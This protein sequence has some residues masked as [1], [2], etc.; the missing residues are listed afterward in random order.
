MFNNN[1]N[2]YFFYYISHDTASTRRYHNQLKLN[3]QFHDEKQYI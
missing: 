3:L 2:I 1:K